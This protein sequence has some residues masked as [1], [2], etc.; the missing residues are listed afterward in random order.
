M[1]DFSDAFF[2]AK[3]L[4]FY[5]VTLQNSTTNFARTEFA[6]DEKTLFI[7]NPDRNDLSF[8]G[9]Y[10][11]GGRTKLKGD[12]HA[13]SFIDTSLDNVDVNEADWQSFKGRL[14]CRDE[15]D[16]R[17]VKSPG[18]YKKAA[19]V[20][21]GLKKCYENF[22]NYET[23]GDFYYGEMECKRKLSRSKNW[24]GLQFMRLACGYGE[25]P[26]RVIVTSLAL[27]F[28]C[29]LFFLFGGIQTNAGPV[30]REAAFDFSQIWSTIKDILNCLY[31]SIVSFTTVGYGDYQPIGWSRFIGAGEAFIGAFFMALFVLTVGRKMNR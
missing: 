16:A 21:R 23:A 11:H 13:A 15:I 28:F 1:V 29:S 18:H 12:L 3:S 30:N 17:R 7:L 26:A 14:M 6:G 9:V 25:K 20:C 19:D 2:Q 22:G 31:F 27:I 10:F 24:G 4:K 5:P 8:Q